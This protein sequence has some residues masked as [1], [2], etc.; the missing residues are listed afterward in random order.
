VRSFFCGSSSIFGF[1]FLT[2]M[3]GFIKI[4][5]YAACLFWAVRFF[6]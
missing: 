1:D 3:A 4:L 5:S 2:L 6:D